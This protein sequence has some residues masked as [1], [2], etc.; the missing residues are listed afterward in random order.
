MVASPVF[1]HSFSTASR[2]S[3][4]A[5]QKQ[6]AMT[7]TAMAIRDTQALR[8]EAMNSYLG[9][10]GFG[11]ASPSLHAAFEGKHVVH[12]RADDGKHIGSS[13]GIGLAGVADEQK[14]LVRAALGTGSILKGRLHRVDAVLEVAA[15][16]S[17]HVSRDSALDV[18]RFAVIGLA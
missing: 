18:T 17:V 14:L 7:T 15:L 5:I 9:K 11:C 3:D 10:L 13:L 8:F 2:P 1:E 6:A 4:R 16:A 12:V